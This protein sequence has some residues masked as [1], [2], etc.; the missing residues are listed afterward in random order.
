MANR[1]R[2][3]QILFCVSDDEKRIIK[4]K[5]KQLGT[6]NMGA[7][8]R[9]MAIDSYIIKVYYTEYRKLAA[10][11]NKVGSNINNICRRIN[12]TGHH[13][14][15]DVDELKVRLDDIWMKCCE[16]SMSIC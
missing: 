11:I 6:K 3:N 9:K 12:S 2:P 16:E 7:Y 13:Y 10:A 4:A 8:L 1:T 15:E 5:M 14:Q